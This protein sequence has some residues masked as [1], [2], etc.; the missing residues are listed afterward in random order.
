MAPKAKGQP[1]SPPPKSA[2]APTKITINPAAGPLI[3]NFE[4]AKKL[5]T[6]PPMMADSNPINGGK[7]EALAMPKLNGNANRNTIKPDIESDVK[8]SFNPC[9]PSWGTRFFESFMVC[10]I[11]SL[12]KNLILIQY[13]TA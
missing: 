3:V 6:I 1:V 13:S 10:R 2:T 9:S 12:N 8:L 4:P 7:S 5:T 11:I